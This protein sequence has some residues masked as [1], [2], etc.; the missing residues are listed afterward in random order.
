MQSR[1]RNGQLQLIFSLGYLPA[2]LRP[3]LHKRD[4]ELGVDRRPADLAVE[5]L[6]LLT[7]PSQYPRHRRID[8]AQQMVRWDARFE[9]EQIEQLAL[10]DRLPTHHDPPP[11]PSTS[12]RRNHD[13][14]A[15]SRDCFN[16]IDPQPTSAG[17][18]F[19]SA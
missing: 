11:P 8:A 12:A 3:D 2:A 4:H 13:S 9:V 6:Q 15:A 18:D 14:P 10:I 19:R 1:L 7:K 16:S 5:R 17:S